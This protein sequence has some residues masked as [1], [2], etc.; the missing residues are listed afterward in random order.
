MPHSSAPFDVPVPSAFTHTPEDLRQVS[1][2]MLT[3]WAGAVSPLWMPFFAATS[4]GIGTWAMIQAMQR[5][6]DLFKDM[7]LNG[8]WQASEKMSE[9]FLGKADTSP[10]AVATAASHTLDMLSG[11]RTAVAEAATSVMNETIG[12]ATKTIENVTQAVSADVRS[13][14]AKAAAIKVPKVEVSSVAVTPDPLPKPASRRRPA[15]K[16]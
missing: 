1:Q 9:A 14:A 11:S 10:V 6:Q 12:M 13:S 16:A 7:P 5:N 15:R 8:F 3:V 4:F 2:K